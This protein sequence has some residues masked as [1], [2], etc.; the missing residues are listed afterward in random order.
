MKR[1]AV[2]RLDTLEMPSIYEQ[3]GSFAMPS[4]FHGAWESINLPNSSI[5]SDFLCRPNMEVVGV[6]VGVSNDDIGQIRS[7][8]SGTRPERV[9]IREFPLIPSRYSGYPNWNWLEVTWR[10][11]SSAGLVEAQSNQVL[12]YAHDDSSQQVLVMVLEDLD[13][14]ECEVGGRVAIETE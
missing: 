7:L 2:I 11:A 4:G 13:Y 10:D 6:C 9:R 8:F 12:W 1:H 3:A 5:C 14:I